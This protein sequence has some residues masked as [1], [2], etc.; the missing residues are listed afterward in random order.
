MPDEPP[1]GMETGSPDGA[2]GRGGTGPAGSAVKGR[3]GAEAPPGAGSERA[4]PRQLRRAGRGPAGTE[5]PDRAPGIPTELDH[6]AV[7]VTDL[8]RAIDW[9]RAAFGVEVAHRERVERDGVEEALLKVADSYIQLV[10]P[11]RDDSP[12]ARH[13]ERRGQGL[14]HVGYRVTD[15]A[16]AAESVR[17]AGGEVIDEH[18][19]AGSRGTTVSFVHP[20]SAFGTLIELVQEAAT[21]PAAPADRSPTGTT[22]LAIDVGGTGL[23]ASVLN[24]TGEMETTR[25]RVPTVYPLPP[26]ALVKALVDMVEP[27]PTYD[28]VSVGFPGVVRGGRVLTAPHFVTVAGPGTKVDAKLVQAWTGFDLAGALE[29]AL[30]RPTRVANDADLQGAAVVQGKG[31]EL[32]VT[33]GTGV[34][35]GL[36]LDGHLAP[37]LEVSHHQ[38]R[39]G[40]TYNEQLGEAARKGIGNKKWRKRVH[41]AIDTLHELTNYDHLYIGGGNSAR[42]AGHVAED[43][44]L[45]DNEAGI[46][47][48]IKLW[49]GYIL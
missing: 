46:L 48:G 49:E 39:R 44:T 35:T 32:V 30:D 7:A 6:V 38:F 29:G 15:C 3:A 43:I 28:R 2:A 10:T 20:R 31:L 37:H 27:L 22:T 18:P 11:I 45:V 24:E 16:A 25:V 13:L 14:H 4:G 21:G 8:E 9:Y 26:M 12:V 36:F 1:V 33:L 19:R 17:E 23:K 42:L 34:G 41:I 40:E 47:G 5:V